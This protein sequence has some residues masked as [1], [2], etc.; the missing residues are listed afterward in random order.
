[1][2]STHMYLGNSKFKQESA[3]ILPIR[4]WNHNSPR[5]YLTLGR[6]TPIARKYWGQETTIPTFRIQCQ[7]FIPKP[8]DILW[9]SWNEDGE[10][11][12]YSIPPFAGCDVEEISDA[13]KVY[14]RDTFDLYKEDM[15][16]E[17]HN[18]LIRLVFREAVRFSE[19]HW[20]CDLLNRALACP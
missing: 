7:E 1:M 4:Q 8:G 6:P 13:L 15:V 12:K 10:G 14:V 11:K 5:R 2:L 19:G 18:P 16:S 9:E 20:V 17:E 3:M